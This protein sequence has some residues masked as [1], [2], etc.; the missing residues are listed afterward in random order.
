MS[1][2]E[3]FQL[4]LDNNDYRAVLHLWEEY[5]ASDEIDEP[6]LLKI[7]KA[8]KSSEAAP[9]F[10]QYAETALPLW[11]KVSDT[12]IAYD[13]FRLI[14]D[15]QTSNSPTLAEI[16]SNFLKQRYGSQHNFS[17]KMR[18]V[19]LGNRQ[20]FQ[21]AVANYDLLSH[22]EKGKF[23][24]H[25][26]GWG[27]GEIVDISL[28]REQLLL[29]FEG[30]AGRK[31]MSF[32]NAFK[33][34]IPMDSGHF[35]ARR[36]G[37]PD[38][39][40]EQ[41]RKDPASVIRLLLSDLGP[42]TALE[43]KHELCDW[44]IPADDWTKWWQSARSKIKKDT[45][46]ESPEGIKEPFRLRSAELSHEERLLKALEGHEENPTA[47]LQILYGFLRDF[48]EILK[49]QEFRASLTKK[50]QDLEATVS[51]TD[52]ERFLIDIFLD[53]LLPQGNQEA[54]LGLVRNLEQLEEV[55]ASIPIMAFK[56]RALM[57]V[58]RAHPQWNKIFL[59]LFSRIDDLPVKDYLLKELL[60]P[61]TRSAL[62]ELLQR[63][64]SNPA[65]S[66][67]TFVWYFQKVI[68]GEEGVPFADKVGQTMFFEGFLILFDYVEEHA[69]Y[70]DLLKK[71]HLLLSRNRYAM[72]RKIL[73]DSALEFAQELNLLISKC[74]SLAGHD[75]SSLN[76]LIAV[77]HPSL[78]KKGKSKEDKEGEILWTTP[79]GYQKLQEKIQH[80]GTVETVENA[81]E[82]EAARALG[83]LR[84]NSEYKFA[85]EKRSR[86]QSE[87]KRLTTDLNKAR[88]LSKED[89][90]SDVVGV[91]TVV[92]MQD[93]NGQVTSYTLLGPWDAD[94]ERNILSLQ[95]KLAQSLLGKRP[96]DTIALQGEELTISAIKSC[97]D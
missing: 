43:I 72:F 45:L 66:P 65:T 97:L 34:L 79:E 69:E 26:G 14:L 10:G 50:L 93:K 9:L 33:T 57:A 41:A 88:I 91:G 23:V 67:E 47:T 83:D 5:C 1:Y 71:M 17:A 21:G 89:I 39:L 28:V 60:A 2:F 24:F 77:V 4:Q 84:E 51:L 7:L 13:V 30:V 35:L 62:E 63:L 75:A 64:L 55:I 49:N 61:E 56:K 36:F 80:L 38:G 96:G 53:D 32:A 54:V 22:M 16:C 90:P 25:A 42:K 11:E 18:L 27:V 31:E 86:L 37:D 40:E 70:R 20:N 85:L 92:E 59:S 12:Q 3:E 52:T 68:G 29:E 48:P 76:A 87:L 46:I 78:A 6:E 58:R 95:S 74:R 81:R 73:E 94:P 15:L 19:G 82:I 8:I 44:V